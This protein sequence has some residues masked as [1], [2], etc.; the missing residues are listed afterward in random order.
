MSA[1]EYK[2]ATPPAPSPTSG[3]FPPATPTLLP[4]LFPLGKHAWNDDSDVEDAQQDLRYHHHRVLRHRV[5]LVHVRDMPEVV[6][7]VRLPDEADGQR[8]LIAEVAQHVEG[9]AALQ[10]PPRDEEEGVELH[11]AVAARLNGVLG[12]T[13]RVQQ[14]EKREDVMQD[15]GPREARHGAW[16]EHDPQRVDD[17]IRDEDMRDAHGVEGAQ[18]APEAHHAQRP[19]QRD[20]QC[21]V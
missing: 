11:D 2:E 12:G 21:V 16:E 15:D 10:L 13:E 17:N 20:V 5:P 8:R 14:D 1:L 4:N 7:E 19:N 9:A 3:L 18:Q 6:D